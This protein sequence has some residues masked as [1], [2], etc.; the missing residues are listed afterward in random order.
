MQGINDYC[1]N[2]RERQER[3]I[4]ALKDTLL[5]LRAR[6]DHAVRSASATNMDGLQARADI[7]SVLTGEWYSPE[8]FNKRF[9]LPLVNK[10][11]FMAAHQ[12]LCPECREKPFIKNIKKSIEESNN[13]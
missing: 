4:A 13:G 6:V 5:E 2:Q 3:E 10:S 8:Y 11:A 9:N 1:R 7:Y 12:I